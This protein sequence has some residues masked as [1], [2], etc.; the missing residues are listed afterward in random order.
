MED[1]FKKYVTNENELISEEFI[2]HLYENIENVDKL[3]GNIK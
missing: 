1:L 2:L 3:K